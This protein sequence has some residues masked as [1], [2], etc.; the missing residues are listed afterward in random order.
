M[1]RF[2]LAIGL[3]LAASFV[4]IKYFLPYLLPFLL[5]FFFALALDRLVTRLEGWRIPRSVGAALALVLVGGGFVLFLVFSLSRLVEE[6]SGLVSTLPLYFAAWMERREELFLWLE[7]VFRSLPP[8]VRGA[9]DQ[10]L[11]GI[12]GAL[13]SFLLSALNLLQGWLVRGVPGFAVLVLLS[14]FTT[15]LVSRDKRLIRDFILSLAPSP[16]RRGILQVKAEVMGSTLGLI[17][18]QLVLVFLT[19]FVTLLGLTLLGVPYALTVSILAGVLDVLP[20]VG[21]ALIFLPWAAVLFLTGQY[22]AGVWIAV[23]YG[24]IAIFRAWA[25][26]YVL[27]GTLGL[28]PLAALFSLYVG[29]KLFGPAGLIWGPLVLVVL[30]AA[31]RSGLLPPPG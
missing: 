31:I 25:H 1:T 13:Q 19:F 14:A 29:A 8:W 28:H 11:G 10:Q 27:G 17:K 26:P 23:L 20:V 9:L 7:R 30:K 16:W 15:Y 21:P 22:M 24:T 18:T 3:Y 12:Y 6:L 5:G 2:Y 4:F